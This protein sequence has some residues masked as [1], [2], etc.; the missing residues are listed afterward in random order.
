MSVNKKGKEEFLAEGVGDPLSQAAWEPFENH[1]SEE[2][3]E[4]LDIFIHTIR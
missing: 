2:A 3:C 1:S 4:Y